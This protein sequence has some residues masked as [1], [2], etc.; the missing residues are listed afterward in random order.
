MKKPILYLIFGLLLTACNT[1]LDY[2]ISGYTQKI[3]VEGYIS[4]GEYPKVYLTLNYPLSKLTDS[5][6]LIE[7]VIRTAKVT[8]SDGVKTEVLTSGWET[9]KRHFPP[10]MYVGTELKGQEGKTYYLTVDYSGY[11]LHATTTIPYAN[12]IQ[13]FE[14][15]PVKGNDNLRSL[16]M[17]LN[18]DPIYKNSYRVFTMKKKDG[19]LIETQILYNAEFT[20]SGNNKFIINPKVT[21]LDSSFT[22]G[23]SFLKGDTILVKLCTID[24]TSTQFFKALTLFSSTTG[25]GND[26]F[27]GEKDK[28]K[29]NISLPGFGIWYGNGV[30]YYSVVIQ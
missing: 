22:E 17:L 2:K 16:Y 23:G 29:S 3:I 18:I 11:T 25:I 26:L 15:S 19:Y 14:F 5:I 6:N 24:S 8:I 7:N 13:K 30:R 1:D 4:T 28:L 10:Y 12:N 9:N 20:L 21:E 27:I